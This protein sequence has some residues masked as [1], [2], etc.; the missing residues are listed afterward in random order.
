MAVRS[1]V[2]IVLD[3]S[4]RLPSSGLLAASAEETPVWV[5]AGEGG[6]ENAE[7]ALRT[8]KIEVIR[9]GRR[10]ARLDLAEALRRLAA[11]GIT[12]LMVEGG[13]IV[14]AAFV[15][16]D[17]VDEVAILRAPRSLGNDGIDPLEGMPLTAI[18]ASPRLRS[19]DIETIGED[20]LER[21]ERI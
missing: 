1:P 15:A 16:A 4:L 5:V 12:R 8:R 9:C 20:V 21:F 18:T 14:A 13:P 6:G 11:R 2:R 10:G 3:T 7:G 17:L 19:R